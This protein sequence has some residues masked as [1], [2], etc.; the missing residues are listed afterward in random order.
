MPFKSL[1]QAR[2]MYTKHP[3]MA[4]EFASKT[5]F[6]TLPEHVKK[7]KR[8]VAIAKPKIKRVIANKNGPPGT[9][10]VSRFSGPI[11]KKVVI[12][13][14]SHGKNKKLASNRL[15]NTIAHEEYHVKHPKATEKTTYKATNA[16]KVRAMSATKKQ[17]LYNKYIKH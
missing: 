15:I 17:K 14:K 8:K 7:K 11:P 5:N 13:K 2:L 6:L 9:L 1:A 4:K 16:R 3:Q 10:G 12:Y